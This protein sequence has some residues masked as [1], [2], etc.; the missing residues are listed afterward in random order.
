MPWYNVRRSTIGKQNRRKSL[1]LHIKAQAHITVIETSDRRR[2][3]LFF[4][5]SALKCQQN[6]VNKAMT[7][8]LKFLPLADIYP[9]FLPQYTCLTIK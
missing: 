4:Y 1:T 8:S 9:V 2:S 5:P 3:T 6:I 7:M